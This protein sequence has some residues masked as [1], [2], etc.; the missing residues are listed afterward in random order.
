ME[1]NKQKS[2]RMSII[3]AVNLE[4]GLPASPYAPPAP[5]LSRQISLARL[6]A[7]A[8]AQPSSSQPHPPLSSARSTVPLHTYPP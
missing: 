5:F 7:S 3:V 8:Q 4:L 6:I 1:W 2:A